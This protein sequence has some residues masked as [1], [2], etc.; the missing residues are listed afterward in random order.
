MGQGRGGGRRR[1]ARR[2]GAATG[3]RP[4][5][6]RTWRRPGTAAV[7]RLRWRAIRSRPCCAADSNV[8]GYTDEDRKNAKLPSASRAGFAGSGAAPSGSAGRR[9]DPGREAARRD[10]RAGAGGVPEERPVSGLRARQERQ[11]RAAAGATGQAERIDDGD[12]ERRAGGRDRRHGR[13]HH[14][15]E[16]E[17]REEVPR[18]PVPPWA[19]WAGGNRHGTLQYRS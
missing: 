5:S 7:R 3:G 18:A 4:G 16:E 14:R 11:V 9:G 1:R 6:R 2:A 12:R 13:S 8:G 15:Q 17:R 19:A 10:P